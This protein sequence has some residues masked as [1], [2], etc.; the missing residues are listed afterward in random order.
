[1]ARVDRILAEAAPRF[2]RYRAEEDLE[3]PSWQ[4]LPIETVT[5]RLTTLR[6]DLIRK[7]GAIAPDDFSR[8]GVHPAFGEMTLTEWL[9]FFLVHE[10]HH[11]Y[12]ILQR[13]R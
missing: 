7:I 1:M 10:G 6:G 12:I 8:V 5:R 9:E 13:V 3:W 4:S 2:P 11:L